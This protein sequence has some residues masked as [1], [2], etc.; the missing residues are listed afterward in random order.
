M[1]RKAVDEMFM[2]EQHLALWTVASTAAEAVEMIY[3]QPIWDK[4]LS[5]FAA[6]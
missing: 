5:K 2:R 1:F 4:S 3:T 6:I